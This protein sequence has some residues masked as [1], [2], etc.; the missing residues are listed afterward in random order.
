M[1]ST[2]PSG[3]SWFKSTHS[4]GQTDCVEVAWLDCA[5]AVRDSK[6]PSGP[7]LVF[8]LTQWDAFADAVRAGDF[9]R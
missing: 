2:D 7:V 8:R 9:N 5:V 6:A 1:N 4:G 3:A